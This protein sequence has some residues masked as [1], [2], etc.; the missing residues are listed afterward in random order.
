MKTKEALRGIID[1]LGRNVISE[2]RKLNAVI[3]DIIFDD[4]KMKFLLE[5]RDCLNFIF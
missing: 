5:L 4:K 2:K 3:A 1:T